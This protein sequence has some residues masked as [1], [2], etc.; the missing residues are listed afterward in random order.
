MGKK[1]H[2]GPCKM[3]FNMNKTIGDNHSKNIYCKFIDSLKDM[4][5]HLQW[6]TSKQFS[7]VFAALKNDLLKKKSHEVNFEDLRSGNC[8]KAL[9]TANN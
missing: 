2:L 7:I 1:G 6:C 3:P 9:L 5:R 4:L 8:K